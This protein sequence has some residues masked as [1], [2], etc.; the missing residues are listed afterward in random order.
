L[1]FAS[2]PEMCLFLPW[3]LLLLLPFW[4]VRHHYLNENMGNGVGEHS[5]F[6][7]KAASFFD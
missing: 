3:I 7:P 2:L 6:W 1:I 5:D 4:I